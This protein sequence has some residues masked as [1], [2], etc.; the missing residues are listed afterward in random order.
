[1]RAIL[2]FHS[3]DSSGS[4]ISMSKDAFARQ[5]AWLAKGRV[6]VTTV[7][8]L[9]QLPDDVDA[10]AVTFDD[11]FRN[12]AEIAAPLLAEHGLPST[13]FVVS[14]HAGGTNTWGGVPDPGVPTL[15]LLGWDELARLRERGVTLGAHTRRHRSLPTLTGDALTDEICGAAE[16]IETHTGAP[17]V[18]FAYPYGRVSDAASAIVERAYAWGCTTELRVLRGA[19][20]RARVPRLDMYYFRDSGWLERWGTARFNYYVKLRAQ[21][22]HV[23]QR[24]AS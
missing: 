9:L 16:V 6:R 1:M 15:P 20:A 24:L 17:P 4:P 23:R 3:I 14:D 13:V 8:D 22:R 5:V 19:E 18:G 7:D 10:A 11:G 21:A 2:T 12:F